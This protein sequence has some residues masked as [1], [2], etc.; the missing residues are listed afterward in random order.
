MKEKLNMFNLN[1]LLFKPVTPAEKFIQ[2]TKN[3]QLPLPKPY[4]KKVD[5]KTIFKAYVRLKVFKLPSP[6]IT[7]VNKGLID[8]LSARRS[9]HNLSSKAISVNQLG[10]ILHFAAG[11]KT[12]SDQ[13]VKNRFYPS[14]SSLYPLEVYVITRNIT[15]LSKGVYHYYPKE[16]CLEQINIFKKFNYFRYFIQSSFQSAPC[17]LLITAVFKRVTQKY[18]ERGYRYVLFEA[19]HLMQNFY[20]I[21]TALGL[22]C[23]ALGGFFDQEIDGLL[24]LDGLNESVIYAMSLGKN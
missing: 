2:K 20:L 9:A 4:N 23:C 8:V 19:G 6:K 14:A 21:A 22:S 12:K 11:L 5:F 18:G 16:H 24:D 10:S 13:W 17:F 15:D 7:E 1:W 3:K